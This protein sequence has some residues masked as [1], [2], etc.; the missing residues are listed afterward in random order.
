MLHPVS[1]NRRGGLR[2][3]LAVV[4]IALSTPA[5]AKLEAP[6]ARAFVPDFRALCAAGGSGCS[7]YDTALEGLMKDLEAAP[8]A[9]FNTLAELAEAIDSFLEEPEVKGNEVNYTLYMGVWSGDADGERDK[10]YR[11][12]ISQG[13]GLIYTSDKDVELYPVGQRGVSLPANFTGPRVINAK[14]SD[15]KGGRKLGKELCRVTET[16]PA[17]QYIACMIDSGG[18]GSG[19][20]YVSQQVCDGVVSKVADY[21]PEKAHKFVGNIYYPSAASLL[22]ITD[23]AGTAFVADTDITVVVCPSDEIASAV[24]E[25]ANLYSITSTLPYISGFDNTAIGRD[26]LGKLDNNF[27]ATIDTLYYDLGRGLMEMLYK[28]IPLVDRSKDGLPASMVDKVRVYSQT[29]IFVEDMSAKTVD[30]LLRSYD[31]LIKPGGPNDVQVRTGLKD[32]SFTEV[33]HGEVE[34]VFWLQMEWEDERLVWDP[35]VYDGL[36]RLPDD[37]LVWK[38]AFYFFNIRDKDDVDLYRSPITINSSGTVKFEMNKRGIFLCG[39]HSISLFPF[40]SALCP[41]YLNAA[42]RSNKFDGSIGIRFLDLDDNY[43]TSANVTQEIRVR[44]DGDYSQ[45][46]FNFCFERNPFGFWLRLVIP[47]LLLNFIGFMAFWIDEAAE[48]AALGI[49]TLLC[50]LALRDSLVLPDVSEFTWVELFMLMNVMFQG[51]VLL[52]S[53]IDYSEQCTKAWGSFYFLIVGFLEKAASCLLPKYKAAIEAYRKKQNAVNKKIN[54]RGPFI[55]TKGGQVNHPAGAQQV[56]VHV[57]AAAEDASA[58]QS[59]SIEASAAQSEWIEGPS[60]GVLFRGESWSPRKGDK[61]NG[62]T[63]DDEEEDEN[64]LGPMPPTA[65]VCGRLVVIPAYILLM[66]IMLGANHIFFPGLQYCT[67]NGPYADEGSVVLPI[68]GQGG[69]PLYVSL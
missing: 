12:I 5:Q 21:C 53:F 32:V 25:A 35:F 61:K 19:A 23:I 1:G 14:H 33:V 65:D 66:I 31:P 29:E 47:S 30:R 13:M 44:S 57:E 42:Q 52:L 2:G 49:T 69:V 9:Y 64:D 41:I 48:S 68:P 38:P 4:L 63:D 54:R 62:G 37:S 40:D 34:V 7:G 46:G 6:N 56:E 58:A 43:D 50:T 39:W 8:P 26:L 45:I 18:S 24:V 27:F 11:K 36:I 55:G 16:I 60:P 28:L 3:A 22:E 67:P 10:I 17:R 51:M 15:Y 59:E 20:A